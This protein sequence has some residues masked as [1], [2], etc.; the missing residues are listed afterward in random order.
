MGNKFLRAMVFGIALLLTGVLSGGP[1]LS[2]ETSTSGR[3]DVQLYPQFTYVEPAGLCTLKVFVT[4]PAD[5]LACME[6]FIQYDNTLLTLVDV[7]EGTLFRNAPY[8]TFFDWDN[9]APDTVSAVDCVLG[10]RSYFL[11]PGDLVRFVFRG[12]QTGVAGVRI[13][14]IRLWDI[15]REELFPVVDP[16]AWITIGSPASGA[17]APSPTGS[18]ECYPNPFNPSTTLQLTLSPEET[19]DV[20]V[21]IYTLSGVRIVTLFE[22][23]CGAGSCRFVW[24]GV[25]GSG[26]GV[27][28]GVYFAVARTRSTVYT[29]KLVLI[30]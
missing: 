7:D 2:G 4:A 5:S 24:R 12:E 1:A 9:V 30:E 18:L 17:V 21:S 11:A 25:D 20:D 23:D 26:E 13:A 29:T 6:C 10:Y 27:A 8:P 28:S 14:S 3:I 15:D 22:G 16:G 19:N